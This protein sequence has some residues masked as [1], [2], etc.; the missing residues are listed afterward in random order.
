MGVVDDG[1]AVWAG[2]DVI[3]GVAHVRGVAVV[4]AARPHGV[5]GE[6]PVVAEGRVDAV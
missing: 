6:D 5:A 4:D 3:A 2:T 1:V